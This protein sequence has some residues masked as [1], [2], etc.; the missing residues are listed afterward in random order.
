MSVS[1]LFEIKLPDWHKKVK[2]KMPEMID[3]ALATMQ[4]N[5]G[6]LFDQEGAYNGH[7]KWA[8]L[9][10][11]NGQILSN[12]GNLRKSIGP[13]GNGVTPV[14]SPG[15]VVRFSADT[16][17]IGTTLAYAAMMNFGTTQMP[18]GV[19]KA[20]NAK[21]LKIPL[22]AGKSATP[23]AKGLRKTASGEGRDKFI[24]RKSVRIPARD[25]IGWNE[26]DQQELEETLT[27][28]FWEIMGS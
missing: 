15:G 28:K 3:L 6:M 18:G 4:T 14:R 23:A 19:L 13:V 10:F 27:N 17:T 2:D 26:K 20:T 1:V 11:R 22:P 9:K 25:F 12:R 7:T 5:R 24:F 21:A 16:L 8:P